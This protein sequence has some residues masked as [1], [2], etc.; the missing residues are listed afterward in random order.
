MPTKRKLIEGKQTCDRCS[1]KNPPITECSWPISETS[2]HSY[3]M[4]LCSPCSDAIQ[5]H[6]EKGG[7]VSAI[8]TLEGAPRKAQREH[9]AIPRRRIAR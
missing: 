3:W 1:Q 2:T 6:F 9:L 8:G 7:A 5:S 4:D